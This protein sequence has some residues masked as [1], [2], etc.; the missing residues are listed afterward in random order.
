M[1]LF[2][3]DLLEFGGKERGDLTPSG[4]RQRYLKGKYNRLRFADL[5]SEEYAPGEFY[6]QGSEYPRTTQSAYC[7]LMGLYPPTVEDVAES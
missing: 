7:E 4:M 5:L 2:A 3:D 1:S 6:V